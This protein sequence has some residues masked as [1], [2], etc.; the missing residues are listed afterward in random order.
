MG[1]VLVAGLRI[2]YVPERSCLFPGGLQLPV[3]VTFKCRGHRAQFLG[4][5]ASRQHGGI[6]GQY[7]PGRENRVF[8]IRILQF[9]N[10]L[11]IFFA[12]KAQ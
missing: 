11:G 12:D 1:R 6:P 3:Q 7:I 2:Q 5:S 9:Y 8:N 10:D 4:W